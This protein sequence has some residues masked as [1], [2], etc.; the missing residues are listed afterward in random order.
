MLYEMAAGSLPFNGSTTALMFD[1]IL[2]RDPVPVATFNANLPPAFGNIVGK[3]LEKD[4]RL[5]YQSASDVLADLRRVQRDASSAKTAVPAS[6]TT[7]VQ[8][9]QGHR[10]A[11]GAAVR[12]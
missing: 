11:G 9:R 6:P 10:F 8:D 3:L 7:H 12:E 4:C 2:N 5:R 1:A